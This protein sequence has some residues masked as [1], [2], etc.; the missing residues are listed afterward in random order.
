[1]TEPT[2]RAGLRGGRRRRG[3]VR[4]GRPA[5][6]GPGLPGPAAGAGPELESPDQHAGA[7][8]G[9]LGSDAMYGDLTVPQAG[10]GGREIP[11]PSGRGLGG[12]S[13]VNTLTWFQGHP[14]DYDGWLERAPRAGAG[15]R[16]C[17]SRAGWSTTSSAAGRSTARAAR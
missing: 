6:A 1:M 5:V 15:T 9:L 16:C 11:L 17:R 7:A 3:R 2:I 8:L 13:S 4:P 14:A 10:A 12:G